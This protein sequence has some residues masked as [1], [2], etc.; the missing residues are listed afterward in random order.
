MSACSIDALIEMGGWGPDLMT[1]HSVG[2]NVP[3]PEALLEVAIPDLSDRLLYAE[4]GQHLQQYG[5]A[6]R[7]LHWAR[8]VFMQVGCL[9]CG[10]CLVIPDLSV[11]AGSRLKWVLA[12]L[13]ASAGHAGRNRSSCRSVECLICACAHMLAVP[14]L[15]IACYKL[16]PVGCTQSLQPAL[17]IVHRMQQVSVHV[18]RVPQR[19]FSRQPCGPAMHS[20]HWAL[21]AGHTGYLLM[22]KAEVQQ[23]AMHGRVSYPWPGYPR[24]SELRTGRH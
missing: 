14:D 13:W 10:L 1:Q 22:R 6:L 24:S 12:A 15:D 18:Q 16:G 19:R 21:A 4:P 23:H 20:P 3:V 5:P 7:F 2:R 8:Q 11:F 17:G 9:L